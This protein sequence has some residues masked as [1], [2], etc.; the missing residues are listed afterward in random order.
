M[1]PIG[2]VEWY[3]FGCMAPSTLPGQHIY[4]SA[5]GSYTS[6]PW[7]GETAQ[8]GVRLAIVPTLGAP[9][10]GAIFDI[11]QAN[12]RQPMALVGSDATWNWLCTWAATWG[13]TPNDTN[14]GLSY[15][16]DLA[17]DFLIWWNA[18]KGF[19]TNAFKLQRV[20]VALIDR[21]GTYCY[22]ASEFSLKTPVAGS[23][24]NA[25]APEIACAISFRADVLG[26]RGRGRMFFP[27][28]ANTAIDP[29]G[30]ASP[31]MTTLFANSTKS[32]VDNLQSLPGLPG[33][34]FPMLMVTSAGKEDAYRPAE[35][36]VGNHLDVQ[37]RRQHQTV[38][39]YT[40]L[41][42]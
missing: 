37:R 35:I 9:D 25:T 12:D 28:L 8:V 33:D 2:R 30:I 18:C 10:M 24:S 1:Q 40:S 5:H 31:T 16:L 17:N 13:T 20:K 42:L 22:G 34:H 27:A 14:F 6:G 36:R 7:L 38:E 32:L 41:G 4:V 21:E 3:T 11:P 29:T 19:V 15:Q 39:T 26:R 23:S